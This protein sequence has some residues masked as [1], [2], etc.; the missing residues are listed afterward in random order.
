[1]GSA[2]FSP[3]DIRRREFFARTPG[4]TYRRR[5]RGWSADTISISPRQTS[6]KRGRRLGA[7]ALLAGIR[8]L[9]GIGVLDAW[10]AAKN[11]LLRGHASHS[12]PLEEADRRNV[13][14]ICYGLNP[15]NPAHFKNERERQR[16]GFIGQAPSLGAARQREPDFGMHFVGVHT[17]ADVTNEGVPFS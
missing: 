1:M 8:P 5:I 16:D 14:S 4:L 11:G 7:V 10:L 6:G 13:P 15:G 9:Q 17:D 3:L 2:Q 12:E